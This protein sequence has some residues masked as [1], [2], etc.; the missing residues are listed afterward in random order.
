MLRN[1]SENC[2][3]R[4]AASHRASR[5]RASRS[6]ARPT[7]WRRR[8]S[9]STAPAAAPPRPQ[10]DAGAI[11]RQS[12]ESRRAAQ[13][14]FEHRGRR[15]VRRRG[16]YAARARRHAEPV[17]DG[18]QGNRHADGA[19]SSRLAE[20]SDTLRQQTRRATQDLL[21]EQERLRAEAER[22]PTATRDSTE[23]MRRVLNDQIRALDKLTALSS[24][25]TARRDVM[26]P[27]AAPPAS[28]APPQPTVAQY[29]RSNIRRHSNR[30]HRI[31][32]HPAAGRQRRPLDARRTAL[33][34]RC[35]DRAAAWREPKPPDAAAGG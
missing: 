32:R 8:T 28:L 12:G 26:P 2:S 24:R 22:L 31:I 15:H 11:D 9:A 13:G 1:V 3:P 25:Q 10:R 16:A 14:L 35:A 21:A 27:T 4:S 33:A 34:R 17:L 29:R 30:R 7:R 23:A 19:L 6:C 20:T 5:T 18:R